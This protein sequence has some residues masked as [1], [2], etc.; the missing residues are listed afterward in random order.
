[1]A[2]AT[3][4]LDL[5]AHLMRRAGFG[6]RLDE[7]E[8][9]ASRP[10]EDVV[11]DLLHPE[12]F[13]DVEVDVIERFYST[14]NAGY[15]PLWWNRMLNSQRQLEEKITLFWHHIFATGQVKSAHNP[16]A[17]AQ[18]DMFRRLGMGDIRT[19]LLELSKDPAMIFWLDN[20]EN[21]TDEPNE[22]FGRELLE[23]FSIGVGNYTE[24][25]V[26]A[27]AYAF[28]GWSLQTP[29]PG[30]GSRYGGYHSKFVFLEDEHD[31]SDKNFLGE[32]GNWNGDDIVDII[33][34][35][36]A[37]ARF[38]S[39]HLYNYFVADEVSV[40]GWNEI[41]PKDPDAINTL[42]ESYLTSDGDLRTILR[43]LFNSD[44]FKEARFLRV[45]TPT[46]LV[47]GIVKLTGEFQDIQ[48]DLP[49]VAGA[50]GAM[51]QSLM[52]PLTVE[53]WPIG[54]GWIDGG[55]L[56]ER[57]NFAVDEI[58]SAEKPGIRFV[59]DRLA[60]MGRPLSP[61]EFVGECV[62]M[63]RPAPISQESILGLLHFAEQE[64]ELDL[65]DDSKREINEFRVLRMLQLIVSTREYQL[66]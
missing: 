31:D 46:E 65:S 34:K 47:T 45:K 25:D 39:R 61:I 50:S 23:L 38:I 63:V 57:V 55:T 64:R 17:Q 54:A 21:L 48:I 9:L 66:T 27:A 28:T 1:M 62:Q 13:P 20:N 60:E 7:L 36:P 37:A 49:R 59:I 26:K 44:F 8:V 51:G 43:T 53:G 32:S 30:A 33:V 22:N 14:G 42:M 41:P 58:S 12:N 56:N 29:I 3:K 18:I 4:D 35:Q 19:L 15:G 5:Y 24:A 10:Y 2:T 16:S 40:S 6:A 11:E 52:N